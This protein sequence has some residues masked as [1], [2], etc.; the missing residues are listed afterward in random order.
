MITSPE[1]YPENDTI[2]IVF[3]T[4]DSHEARLFSAF[5]D[6]FGNAFAV[7]EDLDAHR[8]CLHVRQGG[9]REVRR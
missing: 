9:L 7:L 1:V 6:A 2:T 4:E 5:R 3:D 8:C